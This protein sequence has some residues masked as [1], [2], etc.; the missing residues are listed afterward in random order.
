MNDKQSDWFHLHTHSAFSQLDGMSKVPAMVAKAA[1]MGQ[2]ALAITDHGSM[3]STVQLYKAAKQHGIAPF[4]GVE[5][6]LIDPD[7]D[8]TDSKA[9]R[10][11]VGLVART[12]DGYRG[13]VGLVSASHSRPRFS[14]FPRITLDDLTELS[15]DYADDIILTTGCYF[16]LVQQT[17]VNNGP[18]A[19]ERVVKMYAQMFPHTIMEL[20]HHSICH[21][22]EGDAKVYDDDLIVSELVTIADQVGI[23]VM[24]TQDSHYLNQ[25]DKAAH[26]MMKRMIYGG[27]EDE[28]PGDSFHL[29][30]TDW[31]AEHYDPAVW[32]RVEETSRHLLALNEVSIPPLDTFKAYVPQTVR[33]PQ[34]V[35][36]NQCLTAL[37][38]YLKDN[39]LSRKRKTYEE[40]LSYELDVIND[41]GMAGYFTLVC[42]Y[43]EWCRKQNVC[44]E[45]RGSANGSL[46][47][48][49]LGIT[50]V[51][52]IIWGTFFERFLS[53]DRMKPPDIDM[54]VE[55]H[56]H[57]DL[58]DYLSQTFDTMRI[59]TWNNLGVNAEGKGGV[60]VTYQSYI[61]RQLATPAERA[62]VREKLQTIDDVELYSRKD[63][64]GLRRLQDIGGAYRS[65]GTHPGGILISSDK[66]SLDDWI[67]RMFIANS[68]KSVSQ[69]SM[70][71]VEQLGFLKLDIL[72]Q[73]TLTKMRYCQ[74]LMGRSDPTDFSWIPNNDSAA[75]ALIRKGEPDS[76]LF[77]FGGASK[78]K[79]GRELRVK[80][81]KD[82]VLAQALY[83]P[84]AVDS[85]EKDRYIQRRRDP[86][87][88]AA[89]TYHHPVY[90]KALEMTYGT[91][92]FQEQVLQIM[93]GLGMSV[94]SFNTLLKVVKTSGSGAVSN[95]GRMQSVRQEFDDRCTELKVVDPDA[96][97]DQLT[98]FV[99]YGFN[100]AHATGYGIRAYRDAYL[101]AHF[102]LEWYTA[103]LRSY[104]G[105]DK[106]K[107]YIRSARKLGIR[108]LP[109]DVNISDE[110]WTLD[111]QRKAIRRGLTT[112]K[113]V[114]DKAATEI[115]ANAPYDD[116]EEL[117][118]L[119]DSRAVTGG[120]TYTKDGQLSGVLAKLQEAGALMSLGIEGEDQ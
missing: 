58:I 110:S 19:A 55:H 46:V 78:A 11:H 12:L 70:D 89:V 71:D 80:S 50:Q 83:M 66:Q 65:Y 75:C 97:W 105:D 103:L 42:T 28:F 57:G 102:P 62:V 111:R 23:P 107:S 95:E 87:E 7:V 10:Y 14:R 74:E 119:T 53:R 39:K 61:T 59:G 56:S 100:L 82:C 36:T 67:P 44:I 94:A 21:D 101:K 24:A 108:I 93:Q 120:K 116:I 13:L 26:S 109:P 69:Y 40:R 76:G 18:D 1:R 92:I 33:K 64:R 60:M 9:A 25:G 4:P 79:G 41:L 3:A 77:H 86:A 91:V 6:Y 37:D 20:Q 72:G 99:A 29:S 2:K 118:D 22:A 8:T 16:G 48:F 43:V 51:D 88:R 45:A 52:P 113:G 31:T 27:S 84:G 106:E 34:Q 85:G 115:V 54:D 5:A 98:G 47:C 32:Q 30:T 49:L 81:T 112:I 117:I 38:T 96:A 63:Y 90:K 73:K 68:E 114:G 104:S 15:D 17:L 35:I